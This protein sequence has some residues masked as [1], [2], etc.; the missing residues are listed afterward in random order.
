VRVKNVHDVAALSTE[1]PL[2][3]DHLIFA[4]VAKGK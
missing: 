3:I 2:L 4:R 1:L